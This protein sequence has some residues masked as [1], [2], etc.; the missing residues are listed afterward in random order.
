MAAV[1]TT[2]NM[3]LM[4]APD[5]QPLARFLP[6]Q[7]TRIGWIPPDEPLTR[8]EWID[9]S[10]ALWEWERGRPWCIGDWIL[11]GEQRYGETYAQAIEIT[12]LSYDRLAHYVRLCR[13]FN[14]CRRRQNLYPAHHEKVLPDRFSPEEQD[15]WLD[16]AEGEGLSAAEMG[17]QIEAWE[18]EVRKQRLIDE[19]IIVDVATGPGGPFTVVSCPG[20]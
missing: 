16:K 6:G 15:Q 5:A 1:T 7:W 4:V 12:G 10:D 9:R 18:Q 2:T 8:D 14:F 19:G 3:E 20:S 11:Y 17:R 13:R